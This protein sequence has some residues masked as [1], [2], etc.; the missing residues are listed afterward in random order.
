MLQES[1]RPRP[2]RPRQAGHRP[3]RPRTPNPVPAA[4]SRHPRLSSLSQPTRGVAITRVKVRRP[5]NWALAQEHIPCD[6]R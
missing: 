1:R 4:A 3:E 5:W 2:L 6:A